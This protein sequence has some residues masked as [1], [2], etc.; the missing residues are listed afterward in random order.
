MTPRAD[1]P[2][3]VLELRS[4]RGTGGGPE[5]T[6]L[7]GAA[8]TNRARYQVTVCYMRDERD[9]VYHIDERANELPVDYVEIRERHSFDPGIWRP[10]RAL[11]RDRQI[12]I[13]HA[14]DYKTDLLALM[15]ARTDRITPLATMHDNHVPATF[16]ERVLYYPVDLKLLARF[17]RVVAVSSTVKN[18]LVAAGAKPSRVTVVLNGIDPEQFKRVRERE[19]ELRAALGFGPRDVVI[20]SIGRLEPIKNFPLMLRAFAA[21]APEFPAARLAIGGEG[22]QR[23]ELEQLIAELHLDGRCH[24]LG[25]VTDVVPLHHAFDLYVQSSDSEGTPNSIL[26]AMALETPIVATDVGGTSELSRPDCEALI[27]P[28]RSEEALAGAMRLALTDREATSRRAEAGRL[29][30]E[31]ELSFEAR[32]RRV[33]GIY[34]ELYASRQGGCAASGSGVGGPGRDSH[35]SPVPDPDISE[36]TAYRC[37]ANTSEPGEGTKCVNA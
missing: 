20:G 36:P 10:L 27:V 34:D 19:A 13:V 22:S 30:I 31:R 3:R 37:C 17:P 1:R 6:I 15:L 32:M 26:E 5:K 7:L 8:R 16:R 11:V 2:I 14:H 35:R 25:H 28:R 33:E 21:I 24:L 4:V 12:D 18:R 29:R 23:H 9:G